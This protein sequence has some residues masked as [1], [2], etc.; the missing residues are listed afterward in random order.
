M[1][2]PRIGPWR[3]RPVALS[4]LGRHRGRVFPS[5]RQALTEAV[6]QLGLG[7]ADRVAIPEWSSHCPISAIGMVATPVPVREAQQPAAVLVYEQWGW[8][9]IGRIRE[10]WPK[11]R[12]IH[13]CVDSCSLEFSDADAQVWSL[14]KTLGLAGGGLLRMGGEFVEFAPNPT[15]ANLLGLPVEMRKWFV[16]FLAPDLEEASGRDLDRA[17]AEEHLHR[18]ANAAVFGVDSGTPG[19][20]PLED[21]S[22]QQRLR[23]RGID[24]PIY[25][26][27]F[28]R[29]IG[30][31]DY[32]KCVAVPLH[33][34]VTPQL[35]QG[36]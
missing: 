2:D 26:F 31:P 11:A 4:G 32:R 27:D 12:I 36:L 24:A 18:R 5:G 33:G 29:D 14:S 22:A 8:R 13:D 6:R 17:Y 9:Q 28:A 10:R 19:L 21:L 35:L 23:D 30:R 3:S 15:D 16:R 7:R 20:F 1:S 34:E 25:H